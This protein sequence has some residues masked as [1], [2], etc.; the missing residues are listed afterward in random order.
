MKTWSEIFGVADEAI[1]GSSDP[2]RA[3]AKELNGAATEIEEVVDQLALPWGQSVGFNGMAADAFVAVTALLADLMRPAIDPLETVAAGFTNHADELDELILDAATELRAANDRHDRVEDSERQVRR[4]RLELEVATD[5]APLV[6]AAV[7]AEER[8]QRDARFELERSRRAYD[9]LRSD[10]EDLN[11]RTE[12]L[13]A[14]NR[15]PTQASGPWGPSSSG[16]SFPVLVGSPAGTWLLVREVLLDAGV[17]VTYPVNGTGNEDEERGEGCIWTENGELHI[18]VG[19][20]YGGE[21]VVGADISQEVY[22]AVVVILNGRIPDHR[23]WQ[24]VDDLSDEEFSALNWAFST[25]FGVGYGGQTQV[26]GTNG[27][28]QNYLEGGD[29]TPQPIHTMD[30]LALGVDFVG[31]DNELADQVLEEI[32]PYRTVEVCP[33]PSRQGDRT[34]ASD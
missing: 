30:G 29:W 31:P 1:L 10:E 12:V 34:G 23:S 11:A 5:D 14:D 6:A 22:A 19:G 17:D 7:L 8:S 28:W 16:T 13:L 25:N 24:S 32:E 4:L 21:F 18:H 15:L 2:Y 27:T 20:P 3:T 33:E 9:R 26:T